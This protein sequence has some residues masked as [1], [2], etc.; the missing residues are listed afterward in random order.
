MASISE[1]FLI[2]AA[3]RGVLVAEANNLILIATGGVS[4]EVTITVG[5]NMA[6]KGGNDCLLTLAIVEWDPRLEDEEPIWGART[7]ESLAIE[8]LMV[9]TRVTVAMLE[10]S[11]ETS[12]EILG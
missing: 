6:E 8:I 11:C 7:E 12:D 2:G 5:V 1:I 3:S 9:M 10:T 4:L